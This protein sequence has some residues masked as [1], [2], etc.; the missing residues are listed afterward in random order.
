MAQT[1]IDNKKISCYNNKPET[2]IKNMINEIYYLEVEDKKTDLVS[3]YAKTSKF[4]EAEVSPDYYDYEPTREEIIE[5]ILLRLAHRYSPLECSYFKEYTGQPINALDLDPSSDY[6]ATTATI[7]KY[8]KLHQEDPEKFP[9]PFMFEKLAE[10]EPP[11]EKKK[12]KP[13]KDGNSRK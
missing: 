10:I 4:E 1:I 8:L 3:Y 2:K 12:K 7:R 13:K 6:Y 11:M 5:G 9:T